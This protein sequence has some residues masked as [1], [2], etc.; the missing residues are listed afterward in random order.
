MRLGKPQCSPLRH[1]LALSTGNLL[2]RN[3]P[4]AQDVRRHGRRRSVVARVAILGYACLDHRFGV[5]EFPP[6]R[7]RTPVHAYRVDVGGPGAVGALAVA[8][9]GGEAI[10]IGRRGDDA[11]GEDVEARLRADAVDTSAF[12]I[13]PGASTPVSGILIDP[14][15]ERHIFPFAGGDFPDE[16]G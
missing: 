7:A 8:R 14:D 4:S 9:L 5:K 11:A 16:P 12:R 2:L 6:V 3:G 13:F 10:L 15:G 1:S